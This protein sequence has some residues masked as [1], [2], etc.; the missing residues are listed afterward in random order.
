M[1]FISSRRLLHCAARR[2][3]PAVLEG[4]HVRQ[5][6][7]RRQ[8]G[9]AGHRAERGPDRRHRNAGRL[10]LRERHGGE[11][12]GQGEDM[13]PAVRRFSPAL[14]T[15]TPRARLRTPRS[16]RPRI[17]VRYPGGCCRPMQGPRP[18]AIACALPAPSPAP[19][20]AGCRRR[21]LSPDAVPWSGRSAERGR[22][23]ARSP[24]RSGRADGAVA[25]AA[26]R[27]SA[28]RRACRLI[29]RSTRTRRASSARN[30][31]R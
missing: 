5:F 3:L 8:L 29:R 20:S 24:A 7:P 27:R 15:T 30:S 25:G 4:E 19:A 11:A 26:S 6:G 21:W 12:G 9:D 22:R 23:D 31:R 14:Y 28:S 13:R 18:A 16:R 17:S 2:H 10:G 1:R